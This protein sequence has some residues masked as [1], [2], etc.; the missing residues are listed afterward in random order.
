W[1]LA[2]A[3]QPPPGL[4]ACAGPVQTVRRPRNDLSQRVPGGR[5][6]HRP[7]PPAAGRP[8]QDLLTLPSLATSKVV[9][10]MLTD[11]GVREINVSFGLAPARGAAR[12]A[13]LPGRPGPSEASLA[14]KAAIDAVLAVLLFIPAAPLIL[15]SI[16]LVR[17]TSR[18]PAIY[19]QTRLGLRGRHYR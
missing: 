14:L 5:T 15:L 17:L 2:S 1:H 6:G 16:V 12:P 3:R 13:V 19:S 11:S 18:G 9:P 8:R 4:R 10:L 7:H